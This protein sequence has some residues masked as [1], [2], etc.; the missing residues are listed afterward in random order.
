M[1]RAFAGSEYARISP[2][3]APV[4]ERIYAE[5]GAGRGFCAIAEGLTRDGIPSPSARWLRDLG[6]AATLAYLPR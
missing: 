2:Q 4:I 5:F 6:I 3:R 1:D